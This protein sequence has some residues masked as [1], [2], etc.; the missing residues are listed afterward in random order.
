MN[1]AADPTPIEDVHGDGR[2]M[3]MHNRFVCETKEKEPDVL[4]IGDSV[5][6]H[7]GQ[8]EIWEKSFA[9][10]HSLNFGIGGDATQNVLWRLQNGELEH[11]KPKVVVLQIGTNNHGHSADQVVGGIKAIVDLL[12]ENHPQAYIVVLAILPRGQNPN[13]LRER[14]DQVNQ[15]LPAALA[16]IPR[17][18]VVNIDPGFIQPDGSIS[19]HDMFDYLHLTRLGYQKSFDP[20]YDLLL[21]LLSE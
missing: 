17:V 11:I 12:S 7:L 16:N 5:V 14:N 15:S 4:F 9:P 18:Q 19:H 1:P 3:S 21:Q 10:M 2:W 13:P 20:I 8:T 6:Q